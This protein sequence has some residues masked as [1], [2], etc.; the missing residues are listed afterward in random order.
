M[1]DIA[2]TVECTS[3]ATTDVTLDGS[4]ST[5]PEDNIVLFAWRRGSRT[6]GEVGGDPVVHVSQP[7]GVTSGRSARGSGRVQ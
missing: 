1:H 3:P 2:R 5:E 7:L 6:G 4:A